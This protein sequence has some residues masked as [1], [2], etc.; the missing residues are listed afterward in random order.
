MAEELKNKYKSAAEKFL[1]RK[2]ET[3]KS[4]KPG[5]AFK[6]LK[7]M[8]AQPG[9]CTEDRTFTLPTHQAE[10]LTNKQSAEKIA[11]YFAGISSEYEPIEISKLPDRVKVRLRSKSTPPTISELACYEK[12]V[13]AK[14]P[15]SGVPGDL[16]CNILKEFSVLK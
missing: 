13:A 2:I 11:N 15:Q 5:Q 7:S 10:G 16:P 1:R 12:I 6:V 8:G 3:L 9:E 14:K 4:T